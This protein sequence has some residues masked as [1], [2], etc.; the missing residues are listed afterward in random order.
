MSLV[1]FSSSFPNEF[2]KQTKTD[3]LDRRWLSQCFGVSFSTVNFWNSKSQNVFWMKWM[4]YDQCLPCNQYCTLRILELRLFWRRNCA[5]VQF[6]WEKFKPHIVKEP[7]SS[8]EFDWKRALKSPPKPAGNR[9]VVGL[10][11]FLQTCD[12]PECNHI[13]SHKTSQESLLG[14]MEDAP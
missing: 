1:R 9:N 5:W 7:K 13:E 10:S 2:S 3:W 8:V 12:F 14:R 11:F 4:R 6:I